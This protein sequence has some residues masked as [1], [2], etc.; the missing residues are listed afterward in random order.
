MRRLAAVAGLAALFGAYSAASL[1]E[2]ARVILLRHGEKKNSRD[3]CDV[4]QLRAQALSQQY[5]GK[6][7]PGNETIYGKGGAPDA[8][9]AITAHTQETATPSAESWGME[10]TVFT[11]PP[12]DPDEDSDLDT[13][14]Q[15]A[16]TALA[17][18]KY[19]GKIV[20]VV[21][22]HKH[23]AKKDLNEEGKTL[24]ALLKLGDIP[25][26]DAPKSWK[27]ANYDYIWIVDYTTSPPTFT[28]L[29]QRYAAP[30]YA[31]VPDNTWGSDPDESRFAEFYR[32]CENKLED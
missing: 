5:L 29:Q 22:E 7:A 27:G 14:T 17:S 6:G 18:A 19:D 1:A 15:K 3:L 26:A 9:F 32:D 25:D 28:P 16:A 10:P 13:Q 8:F 12:K 23:I 21:W 2:P 31:E 24:W 20:V 4:G 11:V 30:A